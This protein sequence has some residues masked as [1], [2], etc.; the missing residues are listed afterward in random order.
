V[1][2]GLAL[3]A[4]AV[5]DV[6]CTAS[7]THHQA[8]PTA[9]PATTTTTQPKPRGGSVRVAV[10]EPPDPAAP[11][12]GGA[13]VRALVLP[14][15][16]V[17]GPRG[18]WQPSLVAP[19]SDRTAPD[20]RSASFVLRAGAR[21]TNGALIGGADLL[22][23]ADKRF[24]AGV[25]GPDAAGR[26]T[27]RFTQALPGWRRLWSGADSISAPA[28]GVWGGPF[29]VASMTPGLETVLHRNDSWWGAPEPYL[30]EVRLLLVPD[31]VMT[32][33][34]FQ[35]H[36]VDVVW[37]PAYTVRSQQY[38]VGAS[39]GGAGGPS[40]WD[41]R[42]L[43]NPARLD[44]ATRKAVVAIVERGLFVG[45]LLAGEGSVLNGWAGPQ[46]SAWS[47]VGQSAGDAAAL[48]GKTVQLTGEDEEPMTALLER[49]L[50]RR[51][52]GAGGTIE[53]RNAEAPRVEGW[54]A[55][56]DY[57]AAVVIS[58]DGPTVC[59]TCRWSSLD[60][61]ATTAADAGDGP[62]A[63]RL[64]AELRD[65]AVVL[66]L[67]RPAPF[68]AFAAE[69][70]GVVGNGEALSAAWNAWEWWRQ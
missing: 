34:L 1:R 32:R 23:S 48:K 69:V 18:D 57:A 63:S 50:Q 15:L 22:R 55:A 19:G 37:P 28:P 46:D 66:P 4:A 59:W 16:F 14:Q 54:V 49:A 7:C 29:T 58:Y 25:D 9:R 38:G 36:K 11:T 67:W 65:Q 52:Q 13:A 64:E 41:V 2:R 62:A 53:L 27:V 33:Q 40:G 35:Q 5:L 20:Q 8:R 6:L 42:L 17:A 26:I 30:D 56:G 24:V 70:H 51:A 39:G 47:Q 45:T 43:L 60:A 31:S 21:W 44:V 10:W 3:A 61:A 12:L 68:I